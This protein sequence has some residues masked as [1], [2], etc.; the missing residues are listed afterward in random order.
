MR[1]IQLSSGPTCFQSMLKEV[2]TAAVAG[3]AR[4]S[5]RR[6]A[7]IRAVYSRLS[8]LVCGPS[9]SI[10]TPEN[11][12]LDLITRSQ[13]ATR[14]SMR[15]P[16]DTASANDDPDPLLLTDNRTWRRG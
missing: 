13:F 12:W 6:K 11:T 5:R 14:R 10:S 16:E 9:Q 8:R 1:L 7:R 4:P 15:R 3:A 2:E